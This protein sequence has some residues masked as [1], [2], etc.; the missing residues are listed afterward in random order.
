MNAKTGK[1][2]WS[3]N[4]IPQDERDQGWEILV[5]LGS[6]ANAMGGDWETPS[7]DPELILLY[8]AV[9]NLLKI[10]RSDSVRICLPILS[11]RWRS[12]RAS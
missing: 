8:V 1:V 11:W 2:I 9:A 5:R 4:T 12:I 6:A 10:V 7:I 3:F